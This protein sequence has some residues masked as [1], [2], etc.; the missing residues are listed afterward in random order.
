MRLTK[1]LLI[2]FAV[3]VAVVCAWSA[4]AGAQSYG[5]ASSSDL[6]GYRS[7]SAHYHR[8]SS[9]SNARSNAARRRARQRRAAARRAALRRQATARRVVAVR[10][11]IPPAVRR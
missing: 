1:R 9:A 10:P 3:T 4:P 2:Q 7:S 11:A 8:R 5:G 6:L